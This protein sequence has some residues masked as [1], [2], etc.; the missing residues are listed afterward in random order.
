[1]V[2]FLSVCWGGGGYGGLW[3][4]CPGGGS[5][6]SADPL[7]RLQGA[8]AVQ[9]VE[10]SCSGAAESLEII[11]LPALYSSS[12]YSGGLALSSS[13][14]SLLVSVYSCGTTTSNQQRL[15]RQAKVRYTT[16]HLSWAATLVFL[17]I[18]LKVKAMLYFVCETLELFMK[19]L[20]ITQKS[21]WLHDFCSNWWKNRLIFAHCPWSGFGRCSV[22][23]L[24]SLPI[25]Q[26]IQPKAALQSAE[27]LRARINSD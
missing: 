18:S 2:A 10:G 20:K 22:C 26:A 11:I 13:P 12:C 4:Y 27:L 8:S 23:L 6:V 9:A 24:T 1:M 17:S 25:T 21:R 16:Q 14:R 19:A 15:P 3:P 7:A 5:F